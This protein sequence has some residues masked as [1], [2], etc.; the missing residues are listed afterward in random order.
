MSKI[1]DVHERHGDKQ[2]SP[3]FEEYLE[4]VYLRRAAVGLD[5]L[6]GM[7]RG[8]VVQV[9][10]GEALQYLVELYLMTSYR[11]SKAYQGPTHRVYA[12]TTTSQFPTLFVL[13]PI[14]AD[15]RDSLT[16]I[17]ELYPR[18]KEKPNARYLGEIYRSSNR[19]EVR[20]I[21]EGQ[22]IRFQDSK[23]I[24]NAFLGNP[25][26]TLTER[27]YFTNNIVVYSENDLIDLDSLKLGEPLTLTADEQKKLGRADEAHHG[28]GFHELI[29]G[30][31][32]LATRVFCDDREHAIL[33][34]LTISPYYF[35]GAYDIPEMNSSTNV[36]RYPNLTDELISPAKVFTANNIPFYLN[37]IDKRPSPTEDFVRNFGRRMHHI[38][39]EV[40]DGEREG[41]MKNIDY[42]VGELAKADIPFLADIIGKC[43]DFP[44]LKQIFSKSSPYSFLITEYVQRCHDFKGFFTKTNVAALTEAA[45][46]DEALKK[47][48]VFD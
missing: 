30:I 29:R 41:G 8:I 33:E 27:S 14:A 42:V 38:A 46:R 25:N 6:I 40:V 28:L 15:Y 32:H 47:S 10:S 17:N 11:L 48:D 37:S 3:F 7:L 39:Y 35:W 18:A 16:S 4:K 12:L 31:D 13:E 44:D 24:R 2:N 5:A 45:G 23:S 19:K 20:K 43:D 34:F 21:L 26:F 36:T 1:R 22:E 9:S